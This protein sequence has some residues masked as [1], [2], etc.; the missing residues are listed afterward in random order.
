[1]FS[2]GS[3]FTNVRDGSEDGGD[4]DGDGDDGGDGGDGDYEMM[5]W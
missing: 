1:M 4:G 3:L 5:T 2:L